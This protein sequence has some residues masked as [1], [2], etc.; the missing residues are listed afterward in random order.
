MIGVSTQALAPF[1]SGISISQRIISEYLLRLSV[2]N[3]SVWI[4]LFIQTSFFI[5]LDVQTE[6]PK[7]QLIWQ[8]FDGSR[9][10]FPLEVLSDLEKVALNLSLN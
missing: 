7:M 1:L 5:R 8:L 6:Y 2:D 4:N 3:Q 10:D 9:Q